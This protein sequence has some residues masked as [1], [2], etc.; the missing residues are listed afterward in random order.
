MHIFYSNYEL[1]E[2]RA[3]C[4]KEGISITDIF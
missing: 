1:P 4:K 3:Y 2:V